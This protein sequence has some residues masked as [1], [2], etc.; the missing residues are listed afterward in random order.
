MAQMREHLFHHRSR[1]T[2]QQSSLWEA[3]GK[4]KRW[5]A[6]RCRHVHVS[7]LCSGEEC[8]QAVVDFPVATEVGKLPRKWMEGWGRHRG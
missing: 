1:W 6:G 2:D 5:K 4:T 8:D 3:M 7:E